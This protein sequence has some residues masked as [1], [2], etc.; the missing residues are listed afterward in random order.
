MAPK[1][2]IH[3]ADIQTQMRDGR[4]LP[5]DLYLPADA[6]GPF[7]TVV[8]RT[9]HYKERAFTPPI[10]HH[11]AERGYAVLAQNTAG[12]WKE[13]GDVHPF[14]STDWTDIEDGY[15]TIEWAASQPWCNGKVGGFGYSYPSWCMWMLA[16]TRP[17]HLVTLF[18]GGQAPRTTD[19][20]LGGVFRTGRQLQWTVGPMATLLQGREAEPPHGPATYKGYWHQKEHIDREKW[21]WYLP[22][23]DLPPE[24]IGG[25]KARFNEWLDHIHEDR[26]HIIDSFEQI[27][28]PIFHRTSWYDHLSRTAEMFT[29]MRTRGGTEEARKN[30]RMIIGPWSHSISGIL[31]RQVGEVDFGPEAELDLD[32][33][34][35]R[36]FD[37]W[38][39]GEENGIMDT[40]PVR[41]FVMGAGRWR[42]EDQ[43]PPAGAK[44]TDFYFHSR[45]G[46]NT[47]FGDGTL[48]RRKPADEKPDTYVYDPRDPVMTLYG[49]SCQHEPHDQRVLDHRRDVL[50]YQTD[51][52][53]EPVEV[54]GVPVL[55]LHASSS[56]R[57][58]DFTV[59]LID[60]WPD[61]FAQDLCYGI[62]RAR[63]RHGFDAP[64]L[65]KPGTVYE[66]TIELLPTGN[67]FQRGHRIR[68]DVSSSN[69]PDFDRNHN[70][71]G[72]DYGETTLVAAE[73]TVF[74]DGSRPSRISLPVVS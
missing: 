58:T 47:P 24:F 8:E 25:L 70:T 16:P 61:G 23:K 1:K 64:R 32:G 12:K 33:L 72:D 4:T 74:H 46:A 6:D 45:G 19:W 30:Q 43:W 63:F 40:A 39:K 67:L 56:A 52:L 49:H 36:W 29:G 68:V 48:S 11:L 54:I 5:A 13:E 27:T 10:F 51:P 44:P 20:Q 59:K 37:Y 55:T 28:V 50:V 15:D 73:Q 2:V 7:P 34:M 18:T 62:L 42:E 14:F 69:F 66:L 53:D 21:L 17:P 57:D 65:M 22:M 31:P 3:R 9:A 26:W 41:L 35:T 71:G 38:L 60:V